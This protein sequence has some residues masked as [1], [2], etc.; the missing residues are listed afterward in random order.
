[1]KVQ[2]ILGI[3]LV[4]AGIVL[5]GVSNYIKK[6]V[7]EGRIEIAAGQKKVDSARSVFSLSPATEPV[8]KMITSGGQKRIDEGTATANYYERMAG[9]LQIGGII[10]MVAG[11]LLFILSYRRKR[12]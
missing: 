6:Q 2:R 1:M 3:L 10:A 7:A 9:N 5:L 11:A 8:G 4:V 12:S